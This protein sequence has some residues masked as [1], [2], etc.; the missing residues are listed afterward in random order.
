MRLTGILMATVFSRLM[1][2]MWFEPF[3]LFQQYFKKNAWKYYFSHQLYYWMI[4][5]LC[6]A[7]TYFV[8][9][10]I[11]PNISIYNLLLKF[12]VCLILPNMIIILFFYKTDEMQYFKQIG[13]QLIEKVCGIVHKR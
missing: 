13:T 7:I 1:T 4:F 3:I 9:N 12:I 11:C 6:S 2:N 5:S 8:A 10:T